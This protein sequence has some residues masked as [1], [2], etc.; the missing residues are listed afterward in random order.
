MNNYLSYKR[1]ATDN[2]EA[3]P[4]GNGRLGALV[5]GDPIHER[6]LLNEDTLWSGFPCDTVHHGA[7]QH[8]GRVRKLI[9]E[10]H[11]V[12][13]QKLIEEKMLGVVYSESYLPM[14]Q[15]NI[16]Y[17]DCGEIKNYRRTLS[18]HSGIIETQFERGGV[19]CFG[20]S[21]VSSPDDVFVYE[22]CFENGKG[23][24]TISIT[25]QLRGECS[26][27]NN[28]II[29][30]GKCPE[31]VTPLYIDHAENTVDYGT[32]KGLDFCVALCV[33]TDGCV[34]ENGSYISVKNA[35]YAK[36]ICTSRNKFDSTNPENDCRASINAACGKRERLFER[37][38]KDF[39]SLFDRVNL[40]LEKTYCEEY[41]V[42][43][44]IKDIRN[45]KLSNR[46]IEAIFQFGRY[47]TISSSRCGQPANLQGIWNWDLRPAWSSNWTTNINLPMNYWPT[48][49]CNLSECV[50]PLINWIKKLLPS[51]E[52]T[53]REHYGAEGWCMH[54][55]VDIWG[56]TTPAKGKAPYAMWPM[57]G[58]WLCSPIYRHWRY[59]NDIDYLRNTAFPIMEGA[60]RFTI[61]ML[62]EDSNGN[63]V[64]SP[65]TSPENTFIFRNKIC[66]ITQGSAC[67]MELAAE[68]FGNY[69]KAC[70]TLKQET[71]ILN[72]VKELLLKLKPLAVDGEGR[73][74]EW[75]RQY[76]EAD[77]G[78]RHFS[79]LYGCY[80]GEQF[81]KDPSIMKASEKLFRNR[82]KNGGCLGWSNAWA[83]C[84]AA[85]YRD[86][87][88]AGDML[89][90][91][92]IW[93]FSS[94][95]LS[96]YLC[97]Q[98]LPETRQ[99]GTLFSDETKDKFFQ[100]DANFGFSAAVCELLMRIT[101]EG[102][103]LLPCL[104][105]FLPDG[106][107]E[108]LCTY[109][110]IIL[111]FSWENFVLKSIT[112]HAGKNCSDSFTLIYGNLQKVIQMIPNTKVVFY[113]DAVLKTIDK[114]Y[115]H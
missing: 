37:Q 45:G 102:T 32:G 57:A 101:D 79:P 24:F 76:E 77:P 17:E 53:A 38:E 62:V 112:V 114:D 33:I 96:V 63:Y 20:R 14:C 60:V 29:F 91:L 13:A 42:E 59:T 75:G 109:G 34:S 6:I 81:L 68:L 93:A 106:A 56:M 31:H 43:E 23:N 87:S 66:S 4:L 71:P 82:V 11:V 111:D 28:V 3:M 9:A 19:G 5:F 39:S 10:N 27:D 70:D 113:Y 48:E 89:H 35:G 90:K 8:L 51:G 44:L 30:R 78:H 58:L 21:C 83:A 67:D 50:E 41:C 104:P 36:I 18:M 105:E 22:L 92:M 55:N 1:A 26:A 98:E 52:Q 100:I 47:L 99:S 49:Q 108:G 7:A 94:N 95:L 88:L 2:F 25:S 74:L 69:I 86:A 103:E 72:S 65:S 97:S 54:H 40:R 107:V 16:D 110:D 12:E 84:L 85:R 61:D 46:F 80:P 115:K 64:T 73:L 15:V